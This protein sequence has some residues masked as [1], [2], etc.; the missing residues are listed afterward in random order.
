[1]EAHLQGLAL[2]M[3]LIT[4]M[5]L[6][7]RYGRRSLP[8]FPAFIITLA[9][10]EIVTLFIGTLSIRSFYFS[11][12]THQWLILLVCSGLLSYY[13][14][15]TLARRVLVITVFLVLGATFGLHQH[16]LL[17]LPWYT[18]PKS[19]EKAR[20][21]P[22]NYWNPAWHT[23][24]TNI[25]Y[26]RLNQYCIQNALIM[27]AD[28]FC[29]PPPRP[30]ELGAPLADALNEAN[31]H[32]F[33]VPNARLHANLHAIGLLCIIALTVAV[34]LVRVLRAR[35][36]GFA[37]WR[38]L[39]FLALIVLCVTVTNGLWSETGVG[40][41]FVLTFCSAL[42]VAMLPDRLWLQVTM[43]VLMLSASWLLFLHAGALVRYGPGNGIYR[44]VFNHSRGLF[45]SR[46]E[47]LADARE[48]LAPATSTDPHSYPAGW[49]KDSP[50]WKVNK[51][52]DSGWHDWEY[53]SPVPTWHSG[54][55]GLCF[56]RRDDLWYPGGPLKEGVPRLEFRSE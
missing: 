11:L 50:A 12:F 49:L 15:L 22:I 21:S 54:L 32:P 2:V 23:W 3:V 48:A 10:A 7:Q 46:E 16:R 56:V 9:V 45:G 13:L 8:V 1:M 36:E 25:E 34:A 28:Q 42:L 41:V 47:I 40:Q 24:L 51:L 4:S 5:A 14:P 33:R 26:K 52:P 38:L 53:L 27:Y 18:P 55:T 30:Y 20:L 44:R 37:I 29:P 39:L 6:C 35:Q 19:P 17:G 31:S 43:L